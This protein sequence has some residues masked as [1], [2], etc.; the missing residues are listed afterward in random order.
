MPTKP[1]VVFG[2]A[3]PEPRIVSL[4]SGNGFFVKT[5]RDTDGYYYSVMTSPDFLTAEDAEK[6]N[7][8]AIQFFGKPQN[9]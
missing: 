3:V 2:S 8:G 7:K 4:W 6:F 9:G 5:F 1:S